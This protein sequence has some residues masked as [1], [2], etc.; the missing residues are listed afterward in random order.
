MGRGR[1]TAP[2]IDIEFVQQAFVIRDGT[3]VRIST[4]EDAVFVGPHEQLLVRVYLDGK[5]R[6]VCALRLAWALACGSWPRG[7][8]RPRDG[9]T[10]NF[11]ADNLIVVRR[12][13]IPFAVGTSSLKRRAEVDSEL[14]A[15]LAQHRGQTLPQLSQLTGLSESCCCTHLGR[16]E[17]QGLTRSPRCQARLRWDLSQQGRAAAQASI[18]VIDEL[19]RQILTALVLEPMRQLELARETET[20][21]LTIKRRAGL[22]AERGLIRVDERR[23]YVV[24]H[25]G[26]DALGDAAPKRPAPWFDAA[27]ISAVNSRDVAARISV[28][29]LV[30]YS[31][32][33]AMLTS[34]ISWPASPCG[35][36][37]NP[38]ERRCP[39]RNRRASKRGSICRRFRLERFPQIAPRSDHQAHW[40]KRARPKRRRER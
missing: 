10:R 13:Q 32:R 24:T 21:S 15:T 8:V 6:R 31:G 11:V 16:L 25:E 34:Y 7:I 12:G 18:P 4:G 3:V 38:N 26:F 19:D 22:L 9:N 39:A 37:H 17:K 14:I 20:C 40:Q 27:R 23:R 28:S 1:I 29:V 35:D 30:S 33:G 36:G 5:I 2:P